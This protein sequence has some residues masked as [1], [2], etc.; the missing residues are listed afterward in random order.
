MTGL[1]MAVVLTAGIESGRPAQ[2][3]PPAAGIEPG[4][5]RP[6][7]GVPLRDSGHGATVDAALIR[8]LATAGAGQMLTAV[9]VLR[10]QADAGAIHAPTPAGRHV[11]IERAL[12]SQ[13]TAG[14]DGVLRLL[15]QRRAQ[16]LVTRVTPL[17]IFSGIAVTATPAVIRELA[18]RADVREVDADLPIQAPAATVNAH[19]LAVTSDPAPPEPNLTVAN[20]PALWNL[21]L[22]GQ[23]TVVASMD[24]GVDASHPDLASRWRGGTNSWYDPNGEHPA[25]PTDVNGHGTATMGVLVGGDAGGTSIGVAP[26]ATWIA[27]KLFTDRGTATSTAVHLGFQWL[28]DPDGNPDTADA[29]DVVN[30]S[31]TMSSGGCNLDFQL[32]LRNLRAAGIL[33]VFSAGN[34]GPVAGTVLSPANNPEAF[35][36]AAM[37]NAGVVDPSSS[38]GPSACAGAASPALAAPGVNI[39]TTDLYGLYVDASGTSLAA[40]HV[41][42]V[43]ALLLG[44][45]PDLTAGRQEAALESGATDLGPS[46]V[47]DA[48]GY[49][50][51]DALASYQWLA[52]APDFTVT[53]SPASLGVTPGGTAS[54][55]ISVSG[56]N[57][58]TGDVTL[59]AAGLPAQATWSLTPTTITGG[60]GSALLTVATDASTTP[61]SYPLT[62]AGSGDVL[63]RRAYTT[64]NVLAPDFTLGASPPSVSAARGQAARY[65][66]VVSSVAGFSGGATMSLTGLPARATSSFSANPVGAPGSANLTVSIAA[67]TP[68]GTFTVRITGRSGSVTHQTTVALT[69]T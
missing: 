12:R 3:A 50:R 9:V 6:A 56:V 11:A 29:P 8:Q 10:R 69:V 18:S 57:G 54:Y 16:G 68:R 55:T 4:P 63:S 25:V 43:L 36:V 60:S 48:Y 19:R 20:V 64:L 7:P 35:A 41:A 26:D 28:L 21:G 58:F 61:G 53:V 33:P 37:D 46:G 15:T 32:D 13:A 52:S 39:H 38:E 62:V 1:A 23:G 40:P 44:A 31:W 42:G 2:A 66:V 45:F 27:V 65:S 30:N 51:L 17:W 34:Y 24:T 14:Q 59:S 49:G 5:W 22:R 67:S 47:D